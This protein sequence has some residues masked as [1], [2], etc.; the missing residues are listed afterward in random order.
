VKKPYLN[1]LELAAKKLRDIESGK[2]RP[3]SNFRLIGSG[4][5]AEGVAHAL[6]DI[7]AEQQALWEKKLASF[8]N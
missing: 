4:C 3:A 5:I 6:V 7:R 1:D 8:G 2:I